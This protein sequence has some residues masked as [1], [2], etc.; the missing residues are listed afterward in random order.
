M[1]DKSTGFLAV[2]SDVTAEQETDYLHWLTREHTTER[3]GVRGFAGVRVYRSLRNDL[4]RYFTHYELATPAVLA[5]EAYLAR[6]NAPTPWTQ[7][8]M[9]ILGNFV[10]GG[11]RVFAE[12]GTG[13]GGIIAALRLDNLPFSD[14]VAAVQGV[15][16][17]DRIARAE[18]LETDT[19]GTGIKT[20]EKTFRGSDETFAWL[21]LIEG[22]DEVAVAAAV[23]SLGM[24]A[25][26]N[27]YAQIF[28]L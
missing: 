28:E 12:A 26:G 7:R 11:G 10:R 14:P 4:L 22:M 16:G 13:H 21:L 23:S 17:R 24:S 19:A 6:L 15:V 8:I 27:L 18:L 5:S 20:R 9:P 3:L 2:W 25:A 1:T